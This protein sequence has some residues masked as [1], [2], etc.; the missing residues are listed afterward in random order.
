MELRETLPRAAAY[1]SSSNSIAPNEA[2]VSAKD[3]ASSAQPLA[4]P[5]KMYI[6]Y[7]IKCLMRF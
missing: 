6:Q 1:L 2:T 5:R 4:M 3:K 7:H